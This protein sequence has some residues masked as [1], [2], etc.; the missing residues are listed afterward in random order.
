[1][2]ARQCLGIVCGKREESDT[3]IVLYMKSRQ[4]PNIALLHSGHLS[5]CQLPSR[6]QPTKEIKIDRGRTRF[7]RCLR[8]LFVLLSSANSPLL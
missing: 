5:C 7:S 8:R 4:I 2:G 1:M 6:I 3:G